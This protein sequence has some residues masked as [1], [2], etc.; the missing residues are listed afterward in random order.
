[1]IFWL[2]RLIA[3]AVT[4]TQQFPSGRHPR[5]CLE[6]PNDKPEQMPSGYG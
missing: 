2:L 5:V 3:V 4:L 6:N 1:M